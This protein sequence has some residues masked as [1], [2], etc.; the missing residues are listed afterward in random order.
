[1]SLEMHRRGFL[2]SAA[3]APLVAS[4]FAA[5][6]AFARDSYAGLDLMGQAALIT[7]KK[8]TAL[9]LVDAAIARV[10][11]VNPKLNAVVT[12]SFEMARARAKGPLPAGPLSGAPYLIKD[13][14][15]VKGVRT[16]MGSR[17]FA[18]QIA[19]KNA[20]MAQS[21]LDAGMVVIG[22]TNTPEFGLLATTESVLLGPCHN[23]WNLGHSS[24]GSSGGAASAVAA[25]ILPA[26]HA[27]DG[28]G[29][30]R[31]PASSC[32]VFGMKPSRGRMN[33]GSD[34]L[35]GD[36]G[37]ENCVTRSVRDSAMI[38]SLAE[39]RSA[40]APLKP[41]GF[42]PSASTK[43]LKIAFGTASYFG[44]EPDA[45]VKTSLEATAKLCSGLGHTI[46]DVK[47]PL[48]GNEFIEE[49]LTVWSAGPANLVHLVQSKKLKPEDV[50]EPWTIG[51]AE[52]FARK[53]KDALPK[54]LAYFK[55]IEAEIAQ[56]MAQYDAWLTPVL[57]TPAPPL[58]VEGPLVPFDTLYDRVIHYV[59]YTPV[60]N[61]A[62]VPAMSVPLGMSKDGLPIGSMFAAAKGG[63]GMLYA[64]AYE[65][66]KA[67]P[68]AGRKPPVFAE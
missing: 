36:I 66:E 20:A 67:Q 45:D 60:H 27:S 58:G 11:A 38:F 44:T 3:A 32:G 52:F 13:L 46:V 21:A 59:A 9:E 43:R 41:V 14:N 57:S 22:K 48:S 28:G 4:V 18:K 47:N 62:G 64:L 40:K 31:I 55:K 53:P 29:S 12:D 19:T 34:T 51:L 7:S 61:V 35:P 5:A 65:L 33:L 1:M 16:T 37:V 2:K 56:F 63:E 49:F 25:G 42:I 39:D 15:D 30:I 6:P 23:P 68:W 26:A 50:L 17:L 8:A 54:A 24:G 10:E